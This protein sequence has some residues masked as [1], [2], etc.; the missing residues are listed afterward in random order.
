MGQYIYAPAGPTNLQT[1]H[2]EACAL[3]KC[4]EF[5]G[6]TR[7]GCGSNLAK[8][9][10]Y[11]KYTIPCSG[12]AIKHAM[13][14]SLKVVEHDFQTYGLVVFRYHKETCAEIVK[15]TIRYIMT[16]G[17]DVA[18]K[19]ALGCTPAK[20]AYGECLRLIYDYRLSQLKWV[21]NENYKNQGADAAKL[22]N[23]FDALYS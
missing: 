4:V 21:K 17:D 19:K 20:N 3:K 14:S 1:K 9:K 2:L 18:K 5:I 11:L 13:Q 6:S 23:K 16:H 12:A 10:R 15:E 8:G 22:C 7:P